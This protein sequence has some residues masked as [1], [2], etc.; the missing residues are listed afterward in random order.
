MTRKLR[1]GLAF[2]KRLGSEFEVKGKGAIKALPAKACKSRAKRQVSRYKLSLLG[3]DLVWQREEDGPL[4]VR[5]LGFLRYAPK[6]T[7]NGG[8][9]AGSAEWGNFVVG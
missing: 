6:E 5:S 4:P 8:I 1:N 2:R 3:N 7:P 9:G